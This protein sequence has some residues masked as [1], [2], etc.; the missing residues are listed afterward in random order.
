MRKYFY[1][2]VFS[3]DYSIISSSFVGKTYVR[4]WGTLA[5]ASGSHLC[6]FVR[7]KSGDFFRFCEFFMF[8]RWLYRKVELSNEVLWLFCPP[9]FY[10]H[11]FCL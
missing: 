5:C 9:L 6:T 3:V 8:R 10:Y 7:K 11:L 1:K 4:L 2:K